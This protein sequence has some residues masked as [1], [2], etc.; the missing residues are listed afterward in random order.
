MNMNAELWGSPGLPP[1]CGVGV[2]GSDTD[3]RPGKGMCRPATWPR[4]KKLLLCSRVRT[5]AAGTRPRETIPRETRAEAWLR[6]AGRARETVAFVG[7]T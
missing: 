2:R 4:A 1:T 3:H 5:E 7:E 6:K